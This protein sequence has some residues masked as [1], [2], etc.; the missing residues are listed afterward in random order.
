MCARACV[1]P[2]FS[3]HGIFQA[4]ILEWFDIS[5]STG[6][7]L[8]Q[9]SNPLLLSL[10]NCRQTLYPLSHPRQAHNQ[11]SQVTLVV[12]NPLANSGDIRDMDSIPRWGRIPWRK[13]WKPTPVFLPGQ[14]PWTEEPDG[15]QSIGLQRVG[16]NRSDFACT[17]A[18]P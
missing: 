10:Q 14:S 2:G 8:T 11:V 12:K 16:H 15:P 7:F 9:E 1:R 17:H 5:F 18:I 6:I 4:R 13:A 3:I